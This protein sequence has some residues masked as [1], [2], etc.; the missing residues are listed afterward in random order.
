M[1]FCAAQFTLSRI[2]IYLSGRLQ[3]S[4]EKID[5]HI[6]QKIYKLALGTPICI[7]YWEEIITFHP[8]ASPYYPESPT[9][10]LSGSAG[11]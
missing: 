4:K 3:L 2:L 11:L 8:V 1:L 6:R 9:R 5:Q 10:L 7:D